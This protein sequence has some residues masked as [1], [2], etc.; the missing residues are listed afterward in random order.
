MPILTS[1][2]ISTAKQIIVYFG[3]SFQDLGI[4][5]YRTVGQD[6][7]AAGSVINFIN[8]IQASSSD[9]PAVVIANL[10][11]S[12][13]YR[14]GKKALTQV[15]WRTLPMK[16]A[17][18]LGFVVDKVKNSIPKNESMAEHV[19]CVFEDAVGRLA[20]VDAKVY[21]IGVAEGAVEAVEYLQKSWEMWKG[22][23]EAIAIGSS[24]VWRMQF[25]NQDFKEFWGKVSSRILKIHLI[26]ILSEWIRAFG[27]HCRIRAIDRHC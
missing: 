26:G 5:A 25:S 7:I 24:H 10:G 19:K 9:P 3:D 22:R 13:W 17:V 4:F 11:Q 8:A 1:A 14:R 6:S 18:S 12:I 15:S 20:H 16:T 2:N 21:V 27:V 23:V